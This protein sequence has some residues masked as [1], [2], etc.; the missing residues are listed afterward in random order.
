MKLNEYFFR[1][2]WYLYMFEEISGKVPYLES[3][4]SNPLPLSSLRKYRTIP[5][6]TSGRQFPDEQG[7]G[8]NIFTKTELDFYNERRYHSPR[9]EM[10]SRLHII[11]S[12]MTD[13]NTVISLINFGDISSL[14]ISEIRYFNILINVCD[15]SYSLDGEYERDDMEDIMIRTPP[16]N[17]TNLNYIRNYF[18]IDKKFF[19]T[20]TC[21]QIIF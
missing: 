14:D 11:M 7:G 12:A 19:R 10:T 13:I 16:T 3:I 8:I 5:I 18:K 4:S 1:D 17:I 20:L 15:T 6:L 9:S 2:N 21:Y